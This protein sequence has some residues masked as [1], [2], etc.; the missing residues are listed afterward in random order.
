[1]AKSYHLWLPYYKQGDDL[2]SAQREAGNDSAAFKLHANI[3]RDSA[4]M[5]DKCA[6]YA[7]K[8]MISIEFA[9]T[10]CIGIECSEKVG[11]MLV[12]EGLLSVDEWEDEWSEDV[13][14]YYEEED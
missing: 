12:E 7:G 3:L 10:H 4:E 9:D 8:D 14:Q 11:D 1:M 6:E 5:L 2:A 13:E